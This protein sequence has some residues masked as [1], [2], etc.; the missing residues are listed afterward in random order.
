MTIAWVYVRAPTC[1]GTPARR[2]G[3]P[4]A[5]LRAATRLRVPVE[6]LEGPGPARAPG[7]LVTC[8]QQRHHL[9]ADLPLRHA[10]AL[11]VTCLEQHR[12]QLASV[13]VRPAVA[14][15]RVDDL[16]G[17]RRRT[18]T[19]VARG[20]EPR[21]D[22]TA[23]SQTGGSRKSWI[24]VPRRATC[25]VEVVT[26]VSK[27]VRATMRSV[28]AVMSS[29]RSTACPRAAFGAVIGMYAIVR[30]PG[31]DPSAV[32][33]RRRQ[34]TMTQPLVALGRQQAVAEERDQHPRPEALTEV[35]GAFDEDLLDLRRA[36]GRIRRETARN[37]I[38]TKS[39]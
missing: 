11:L 13:L 38:G 30:P 20:R 32:E 7:R 26:S 19:S 10:G 36:E 4:R 28:S 27:S 24:S 37:R 29:W 33:R 12:E 17:R 9:V 1:S 8:Q 23:G 15:D 18:E 16:V 39:P 21:Q 35:G 34:P 6:Q 25:S 14:D 3:R 2:R 31:L 22:R 5:P